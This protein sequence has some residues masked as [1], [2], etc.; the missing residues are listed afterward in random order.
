MGF[1][2]TGGGGESGEP[3]I[4]RGGVGDFQSPTPT[5]LYSAALGAPGLSNAETEL[6][7]IGSAVP[8]PDWA[9]YA[10]DPATIPGR[11][12]GTRSTLAISPHPDGTSFAPGYPPPHPRP[13]SPTGPPRP[14]PPVP[15]A[16]RS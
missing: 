12:A 9:A 7:C 16:P 3:T 6:V 14:L 4:L 8:I 13:P 11:G 5:A 15:R 1:M 10:S 2:W